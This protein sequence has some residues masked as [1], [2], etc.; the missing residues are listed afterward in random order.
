VQDQA[1]QQGNVLGS[2]YA[3]H[4]RLQDPKRVTNADSDAALKGTRK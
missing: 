4:T 1:K 2:Y 3:D